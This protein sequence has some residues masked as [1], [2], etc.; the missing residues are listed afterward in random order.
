MFPRSRRLEKSARRWN[1][2]LG[3]T[4]ASSRPNGG[5][6]ELSSR[7]GP[8]KVGVS[9]TNGPPVGLGLSPRVLSRVRIATIRVVPAD[10]QEGSRSQTS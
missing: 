2:P 1:C 7:A 3:E 4:L 9:F 8:P 5:G 10:F 6:P